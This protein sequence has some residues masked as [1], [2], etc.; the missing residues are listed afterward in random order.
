M[1]GQASYS[2]GDRRGM[3]IWYEG[4]IRKGSKCQ[5]QHIFQHAS[6]KYRL[7]RTVLYNNVHGTQ[8]IYDS[9]CGC[10]AAAAADALGI[11]A[12]CCAA[13]GSVVAI[14]DA[15]TSKVASYSP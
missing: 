6:T 4:Y 11:S 10:A 9:R 8:N 7:C 5:S 12:V 13:C 1:H 3:V 15:C 2:W 14:D